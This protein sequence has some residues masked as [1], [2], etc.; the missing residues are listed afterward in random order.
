MRPVRSFQVPADHPAIE[1]H[2]PGRPIVPG[3]ILLDEA[4]AAIT[5][6]AGLTPPLR[7]TRVKFMA[8]VL[9]GQTVDVLLD[10]SRDGRIAFACEAGSRRVLV[11]TALA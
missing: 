6:E 8:P 4:L 11:G 3:V 9:P 10:D 7:L 5:A 1:G 2:F